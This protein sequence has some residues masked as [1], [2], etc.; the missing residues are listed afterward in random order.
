MKFC[1]LLLLLIP[2]SA[3]FS[4]ASKQCKTCNENAFLARGGSQ[5]RERSSATKESTK[6]YAVDTESTVSL[7]EH[8]SAVS[9]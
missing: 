6:V 1:Q 3:S 4:L 5:V 8:A 7:Y 2:I 9:F